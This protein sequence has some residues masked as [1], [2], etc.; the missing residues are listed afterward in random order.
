[1]HRRALPRSSCRQR[2]AER[3]AL[4]RR[5][6]SARASR[7]PCASTAADQN[8]LEDIGRSIPIKMALTFQYDVCHSGSNNP[9][10]QTTSGLLPPGKQ[11]AAVLGQAEQGLAVVSARRSD[12]TIQP[13]LA[14]PTKDERNSDEH[15]PR[16]DRVD[17]GRQRR[18]RQGDGPA[19][20]IT[21]RDRPHLPGVPEPRQGDNG[22]GRARSGRPAGASS[23][24]FSWTLPIRARSAP[25]WRASTDR[26][27]RWS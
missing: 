8:S 18:D 4:P 16:K 12:H 17:H 14:G 25:A 13:T 1:M 26:S 19:T 10:R 21:S 24:S 2:P 11:E 7:R 23:T 5:R 15:N 9:V 20:G 22:E 27:T 6:R 3:S